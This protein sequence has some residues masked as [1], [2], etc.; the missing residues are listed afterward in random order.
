LAALR[1][2]SRASIHLVGGLPAPD[3]VG[4]MAGSPPGAWVCAFQDQV[5]LCVSS[6][7]NEDCES[8]WKIDANAPNHPF[9]IPQELP[10]GPYLIAARSGSRLLAEKVME[11]RPWEDLAARLPDQPETI[12]LPGHRL[13]GAALQPASQ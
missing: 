2:T 5:E 13:C 1:P 8:S 4:W 3:G 11:L 7:V 9:A 10:A 12:P 6:L